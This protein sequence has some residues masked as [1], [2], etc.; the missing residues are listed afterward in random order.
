[1][2]YIK[3]SDKKGNHPLY[4]SRTTL[5]VRVFSFFPFQN[6]YSHVVDF[7]LLEGYTLFLVQEIVQGLM[8]Q[9][10]QHW[11]FYI[12]AMKEVV[13]VFHPLVLEAKT[14]MAKELETSG[15]AQ[16]VGIHVLLWN[17]C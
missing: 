15:V 5:I 11:E 7:P 17:V 8:V 12:T 1:M 6:V 4:C 9:V 13:E 16:S 2:I 14:T 10:I 3:L